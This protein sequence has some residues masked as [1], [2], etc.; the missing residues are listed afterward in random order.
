LT[1][2][3]LQYDEDCDQLAAAAATAS[4]W[5]LLPQL[6]ELK[7]AHDD[8]PSEPEWEAILA[9]LA[10]ATGL[11]KLM[12]DARMMSVELEDKLHFEGYDLGDLDESILGSEVA[13]CAS[14]AKLTCLQ[15]LTVAGGAEV[16]RLNLV[17]GDG[18][19][20]TALTRLTR[21]VLADVQHGV[22]TA[23]AT[24]LARS[25]QQLRSL[26]LSCCCLRLG[27]AERMACLEVIG[28]LTQL[29]WLSLSGNQGSRQHGLMQLTGLS[30]LGQAAQ[31]EIH[32]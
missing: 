6:R 28:R 16:V 22:G 23:V 11:T 20:L 10:A 14:L 29:T 26:D 17:R 32:V 2:L 4:A 13:A 31:C 30:R 27:S 15:D 18:L 5:P 1:H 8:P 3:A 19:A 21:L 24:V 12:L 7:I 9:G 25:L